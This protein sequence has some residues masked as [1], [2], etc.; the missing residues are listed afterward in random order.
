MILCPRCEKFTDRWIAWFRV[1][2]YPLT[3]GQYAEPDITP[4]VCTP[5]LHEWDVRRAQGRLLFTPSREVPS[6]RPFT[7]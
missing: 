2:A 4:L 1:E 6:P 7:P 5:C 3:G